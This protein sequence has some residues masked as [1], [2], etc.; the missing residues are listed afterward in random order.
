M[1]TGKGSGRSCI[2]YIQAACVSSLIS[3]SSKIAKNAPSRIFPGNL[4]FKLMAKNDLAPTPRLHLQTRLGSPSRHDVLPPATQSYDQGWLLRQSTWQ[5]VSLLVTWIYLWS[6]QLDNDGLWF[7][8]DAPRHAMNG[9]FWIDYLRDFT[10]DAKAYA[11]SYYARFPAI[12]PASRPPLFYL[13]EGIAFALFGPSPY[14]AKALVLCFTLVATLYLWAWLRRWVSEEAAWAAGLFLLLPGI[15]QWSHA[16]MLNVPALAFSMAALYHTRCWLDAPKASLWDFWPVPILTLFAILTYYIAGIVVFAI[17]GS[18]M[19]H[20]GLGRPF[21]GRKI[22]AIGLT[23]VG[24]LPFAWLIVGW[25]PIPLSWAV[26]KPVNMVKLSNWAFY[27]HQVLDL[28]NL[29]LLVLAGIGAASALWNRRWRREVIGLM[30][31]IFC[32]YIPLSLLEAKELRYALLLSA[33]LIGL[34]AVAVVQLSEWLVNRAPHLR[35]TGK[36][37]T[38]VVFLALLMLQVYLAASYRVVS[39]SGYK[40]IATFLAQVAPDEPVFFDGFY[41]GIFTFYMRASDPG[42]RRRVVLGGKLLY[43]SAIFPGWQQ[44]EFVNSP[45]EVIDVLRRRGGCRWV[46]VEMSTEAESFIP[47]QQLREAVKTPA[48]EFVRSFPITARGIERVDV[49]RFTLPVVPVDEVELPFAVL[50]PD[51]KYRVRPIPPRP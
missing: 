38:V 51:V 15:V 29:H 10:L 36:K 34:G 20:R 48:F 7:R 28:C 17:A 3:L 14:V 8:G 32:L 27:P 30:I 12:D 46:A 31:W 25:A 35:L 45:E 33:P 24:F 26:P 1:D 23:T 43:T 47:M 2:S 5:L 50:G 49:Y 41:D 42:F 21:G 19:F 44:Q 13:L 4:Q 40:E 9:F 16:I 39:V 6:L 22:L 11:F 37:M 18:I